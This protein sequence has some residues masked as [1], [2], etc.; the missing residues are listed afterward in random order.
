MKKFVCIAAIFVFLFASAVPVAAEPDIH[1]VRRG[2]VLIYWEGPAYLDGQLSDVRTSGTGFFVGAKGEDAQYII[3]N[4]HV[5]ECFDMLDDVF[6]EYAREISSYYD[7]SDPTTPKANFPVYAA[8]SKGDMEEVFLVAYD[9]SRDIAVLRLNNPT[10]KRSCLKLGEFSKAPVGDEFWAVGYPSASDFYKASASVAD[11][12]DS[13][14]TKGT[15]SRVITESGTGNRIYQTDVNINH[16]SSGGPLVDSDGNVVGI[17]YQ[18][19]LADNIFYAISVDDLLPLLRTNGIPY[20]MRTNAIDMKL[21]LIVC[22]LGIAVVAFVVTLLLILKSSKRHHLKAQA[23]APAAPNGSQRAEAPP[24]QATASAAP[25]RKPF[26]RSTLAQHNNIAIEL[27]GAPVLLGRDVAACRLVFR[28]G[29]PGVSS[30]HCNIRFD[31]GNDCFVLTD[32]HSSYGTFLASG[33][34]LAPGVP[35]NLKAR[36]SFYLGEP[37]NT[38]YVDLE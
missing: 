20:E 1:A 11:I 22:L 24:A 37:E 27:S 36:D 34:K 21:I 26:L 33:Q 19:S 10:T 16:G 18:V 15:I 29:T 8:F 35:Y 6:S 12:D 9:K 3:T 13:T 31:R 23:T 38:V 32:L 7:L 30:Q 2:V 4:Y 14:V 28:D 25:K 5:I 17:N